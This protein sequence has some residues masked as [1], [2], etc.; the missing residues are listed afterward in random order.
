[1]AVEFAVVCV[2]VAKSCEPLTASVEVAVSWP[3]ATFWI[4]RSLPT[5]P[6]LTAPAGV[7]PAKV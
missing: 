4:C 3:A 6:T 5:V 1:M 2:L 7:A